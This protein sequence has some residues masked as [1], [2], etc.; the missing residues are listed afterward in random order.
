MNAQDCLDMLRK[1]RDVSFATVDE[2]GMPH[3]RII[4]VMIVEEG[5]LYFCTA[6]GKDF[7]RELVTNPAVAISGLNKD[8]QMVRLTGRTRRLDDQRAWIDRIFEENPSMNGVYPGAARYILDP[9]VIEAGELEFF[10]LGKEPIH[11]ESFRFGD[12]AAPQ[13]RGFL[14]TEDCIGCG[15]CTSCCP[16]Q[17]IGEG[18]PFVIL[19]DSCLHCG[20][21]FESCPAQAIVR[22]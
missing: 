4:D 18:T 1:I 8:W 13:A 6:R 15:T 17:A 5:R 2:E 11:R 20:L 7:Y 19:Q 16:Q 12:D 9:F 14:I 10:D 21:C 22:R 3:N